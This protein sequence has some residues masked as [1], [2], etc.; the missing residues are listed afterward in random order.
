MGES[1]T[2]GLAFFGNDAAQETLRNNESA[3]INEEIAAE[4]AA[5]LKTLQATPKTPQPRVDDKVQDAATGGKVMN[6]NGEVLEHSDE[7]L[8][9]LKEVAKN[10]KATSDGVAKGNEEY[11]QTEQQ[12]AENVAKSKS[13]RESVN[14]YMEQKRELFAGN[15]DV[16]NTA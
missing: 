15:F 13:M 6:E 7:V 16:F 10:T 2:K 3:R 12:K 11:A 5:R 8:E 9:Q 14:R 1:L 4:R